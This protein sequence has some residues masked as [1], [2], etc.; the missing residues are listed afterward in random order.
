M[1]PTAILC[2]A[3][4]QAIYEA[5]QQTL[6]RYIDTKEAD[7]GFKVLAFK[8]ARMSFSQ[9]EERDAFYFLS[10]KVMRLHVS[11]SAFRQLGDKYEIPA[12]NG[13]A[14]KIFSLLQQ[15]IDNKSRLAVVTQA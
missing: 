1:T 12:S 5:S 10:N 14:R 15:T 9:F 8:T 13:F 11:R 6:K 4:A 3:A 2:S 7:V